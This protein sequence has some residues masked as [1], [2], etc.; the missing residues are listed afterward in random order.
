MSVFLVRHCSALGQEPEAQLSEAGVQQS[1]NLADFLA[2]QG[3]TRIISSP[4]QRAV[5]SARPLAALL[6][7]K[8]EVDERLAE[9]QLG[10]VEDGDWRTALRR[11]FDDPQH[12]L[13]NGESS[14]EAQDRGRQVVDDVLAAATLPT[15]LFSHGNLLSLIANSF[16]ADLGFEFWEA[17]S[18]PDVFHLRH[19]VGSVEIERIWGRD[20][21]N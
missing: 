11:S 12:C 20:G 8:I 7:V 18:N 17:L 16:D 3:V 6:G 10:H 9:R 14:R 21:S 4:F 15:A 19:S 2:R 1:H 5:D 13:P